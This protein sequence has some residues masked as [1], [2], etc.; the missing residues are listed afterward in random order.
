MFYNY[1]QSASTLFHTST[2]GHAVMQRL[3]REMLP[4]LNS[5]STATIL[6]LPLQDKAANNSQQDLLDLHG[7]LVLVPVE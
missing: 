1:E 6:Q 5:T 4:H 2:S 3:L 7:G